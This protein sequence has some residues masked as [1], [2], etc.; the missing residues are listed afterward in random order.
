MHVFNNVEELAGYFNGVFVDDIAVDNE[1]GWHEWEKHGQ[2]R[3]RKK[4]MLSKQIAVKGYRFVEGEMVEYNMYFYLLDKSLPLPKKLCI[5]GWDVYIIHC[6]INDTHFGHIVSHSNL[7]IC[8]E[9]VRVLMYFSEVDLTGFMHEQELKTLIARKNITKTR[10][11][12]LSVNFNPST[13]KI[14]MDP[15]TPFKS[16]EY[17]YKVYD[18]FG[19]FNTSLSKGIE[20]VGLNTE[21]KELI[22]KKDKE[23][24]RKVANEDPDGFALYGAMDAIIMF[25]LEKERIKQVN[26]I[27]LESLD[28][29]MNFNKNNFPRSS[30]KLTETVFRKWLAKKYPY[31][32]SK[33][34]LLAD[35]TSLNGATFQKF[36]ELQNAVCDGEKVFVKTKERGKPT[37]K[38]YPI[39]DL[40]LSY[41]NKEKVITGLAHGSIPAIG[42][43]GIRFGQTLGAIVNGGRCVNEN[44]ERLRLEKALD[45]DLKSC[46]GTTMK[47]VKYPIGV[48][49]TI[50]G[51]DNT[52]S[53][54]SSLK[55]M[56]SRIKQFEDGLWTAVVHT[57]EDL[58]F[59]QDLI[60]SNPFITAKEI[61]SKIVTQ[62]TIVGYGTELEVD[63]LDKTHLDGGI[64]L[65]NRQIKNGI[66]TSH[67]LE[68]LKAVSTDKEWSELINK[69]KVDVIIGYRKKDKVTVDEYLAKIDTC[70][71][72]FKSKF[73]ASEIDARSKMWVEIPLEGF[74]QPFLDL[75]KKYK[76]QKQE[77]GDVWD[78][79]QNGCKLFINTL[80]GVMASPFFTTSNAILANN[81]TDR[82][83]CGVWKVNKAL[84]TNMSIT[85]GG[86][87]QYNDCRVLKPTGKKPGLNAMSRYDELN[88]HPRVMNQPILDFDTFYALCNDP[89]SVT[90]DVKKSFWIDISKKGFD[91][92]YSAFCD[93]FGDLHEKVLDV[94]ALKWINDFWGVYGLELGFDVEHKGDNTALEMV[95]Y[96]KSDYMF[97][98]P[99]KPMFKNG[100]DKV[101]D[102]PFSIKVRGTRDK[103][104]VKRQF[105][106]LI[107][108]VVDTC[109]TWQIS[110][111]M[112]KVNSF[113]E[114]YLR[115]GCQGPLEP[116]MGIQRLTTLKPDFNQQAFDTLAQR[117]Y[118]IDRIQSVKNTLE[119]QQ[120]PFKDIWLE[121]GDTEVL[122]N[123]PKHPIF[124]DK[125]E[126]MSME[127]YL[128]DVYLPQ[129]AD[130]GLAS[131]HTKPANKGATD[132]L[133][134]H[135]YFNLV[136]SGMGKTK[137]QN[138]IAKKYGISLTTIKRKISLYKAEFEK[139]DKTDLLESE[140]KTKITR[141]YRAGES[142]QVK[143][144]L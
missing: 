87:Y 93:S 29:D 14:D 89:S 128:L 74:I 17:H 102:K 125:P 100:V 90:E 67:S 4:D 56:L 139:V 82:A 103:D 35:I 119:K 51:R 40:G 38:I 41:W 99:L 78:L 112:H 77:K 94:I 132:R 123:M 31:L 80:Y 131:K 137:A 27:V 108:G 2:T 15:D 11:V 105:L 42:S 96:N 134:V 69:I 34:E 86:A 63:V 121:T 127:K 61:K 46:Y 45:I 70:Y 81:I 76:K 5:D 72:G 49:T 120:Q 7:V 55:K 22:S 124:T 28:I 133:M 8:S 43:K 65:L 91:G 37:T 88:K 59:R 118:Y 135:E 54:C 73:N 68:I 110:E 58:T 84:G 129:G 83:R 122:K 18:Y 101:C 130:K 111:S 85:D 138:E 44:P 26:Q 12:N 107:G 60:F 75:R 53:E 6:D 25:E 47:Q 10:N 33:A 20:S 113:R 9:Q 48:P 115:D 114:E 32:I 21:A 30:G 117:N 3:I 24:M 136:D 64:C 116:G 95:H 140:V 66:I 23:N 141:R 16:T 79:L 52:H 71:K 144:A 92:S 50:T 62:K 104:D 19:A 36:K 126:N 1:W 97:I 142:E 57:S 106:G 39:E 98:E 143:E 109:D 13:G